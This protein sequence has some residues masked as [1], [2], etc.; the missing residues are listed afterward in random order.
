MRVIGLVVFTAPM[1][2]LSSRRA[3]AGGVRGLAG[4]LGVRAFWSAF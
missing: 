2:P 3:V 1:I 4:L